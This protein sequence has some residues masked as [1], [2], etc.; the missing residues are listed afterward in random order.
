MCFVALC[1]ATSSCELTPGDDFPEYV[2]ENKCGVTVEWAVE[3]GIDHFQG[4]L[5]PTES[6]VVHLSEDNTVLTVDFTLPEGRTLKK[7][8]R[9]PMVLTRGDCA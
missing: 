9:T 1:A 5:R 6:H 8:G 7:T 3:R 2:I 4:T